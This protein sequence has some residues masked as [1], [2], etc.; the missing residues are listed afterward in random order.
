M[1]NVCTKYAETHGIIEVFAYDSLYRLTQASSGVANPETFAGQGTPTN[2]T[3]LSNWSLDDAHNWTSRVDFRNPADPTQ[4]MTRTFTVNVLNQYPTVSESIDLTPPTDTSFLYDEAGNLISDGTYDYTYDDRNLVTEVRNSSDGTLVARYGYDALK[5]RISEERAGGAIKTY[6]YDDWQVVAEYT[7]G[8]ESASYIY[9]DGIDHPVAMIADAHT[10]YYHTDT[11]NNIAMVT[12]ESGAV[13]ERYSYDPYGKVTITDDVGTVLNESSI[14]NPYMYA[15]R[16]YDENTGLYY[17]RNRMYSSEF[18]RFLQ[19]DPLGY[20]D[21]LNSYAYV[22]NNPINFVDPFGMNRVTVDV[23]TENDGSLW[24]NNIPQSIIIQIGDYVQFR[25]EGVLSGGL[26]SIPSDSSRSY[27]SPSAGVSLEFAITTVNAAPDIGMS[28]GLANWAKI[29]VLY[30]LD[31]DG[32]PLKGMAL[33]IGAGVGWPLGVSIK[34][35]YLD[36]R[37]MKS[38]YFRQFQ[39]EYAR[40]RKALLDYI[41]KLHRDNVERYGP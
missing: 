22:V 41:D 16:R 2:Y 8:V 39:G 36:E 6:V 11:R 30:D 25:M 24:W 38:E 34:Q 19:R 1:M 17:Y 23:E 33:N 35:G 7:G 13:V 15:S 3:N 5:R 12:D 21:S 18:G 27:A 37:I 28:A 9:D 4:N 14:G 10:Y 29:G 32:M 40:V 31:G 20:V 26:I